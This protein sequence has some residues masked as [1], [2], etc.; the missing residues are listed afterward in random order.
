[1]GKT[2]SPISHFSILPIGAGRI[3][4]VRVFSVLLSFSCQIL[5]VSSA[6]NGSK[7]LEFLLQKNLLNLVPFTPIERLYTQRVSSVL[8][9]ISRQ[10]QTSDT[11]GYLER[12][13]DTLLLQMSD[14]KQLSTILDAPGLALE[15]ERAI[16]QVDQDLT[17]R[18]V[19]DKEDS[20]KHHKVS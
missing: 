1:M 15:A 14:A 5:T 8:K 20:S 11:L 3:G 7:H 2:E 12:S 18:Q 9:T 6:L 4:E 13:E 17:E 10:G 16:V 19:K